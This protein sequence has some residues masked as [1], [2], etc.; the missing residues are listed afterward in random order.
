MKRL[1]LTVL[2]KS[3]NLIGDASLI[4]CYKKQVTEAIIF[5]ADYSIL[6]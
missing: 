3:Q 5:I 2:K 6:K 4:Y 1:T